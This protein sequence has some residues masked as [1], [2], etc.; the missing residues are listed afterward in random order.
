[1]AHRLFGLVLFL[2]S[3]FLQVQA[4]PVYAQAGLPGDVDANGELELA[5]A[6]L[7][8]RYI[9]GKIAD[10]PNAGMADVTQDGEVRVDDALAIAQR[11]S[12]QSRIVVIR[13]QYGTSA[14][15]FAGDVVRIE[16]F[17][18]FM[19]FNVTGGAARVVSASTGYDSGAMPLVFERDGRSLYCLWETGGLLPADDYSVYV[20]LTEVEA[21]GANSAYPLHLDAAAAAVPLTGVVSLSGRVFEIPQLEATVDAF[22]PSPGIPLVFRRVFPQDAYHSPY[23]G[24]LGR[25]WMHNFDVHLEEST[26]G[27]VAFLG[28]EGFNRFFTSNADGTYS[29]AP[30]DHALLARDPDGTFVLKEKDGFIYRFR[31]NLRLDFVEDTNGNRVTCSYDGAARLIEIAHSCGQSFSLEYNEYGRISRLTDHAGRQTTYQ[32]ELGGAHL[33][34]VTGPDGATTSYL[35]SLGKAAA[36]DHRLTQ[37]RRPDDTYVHITYDAGGRVASITGTWGASPNLFS[38]DADGTTHITDAVGAQATL[39]VNEL[40]QP[41]AVVEPD[42]G[43]TQMEYDSLAN[44]LQTTDPLGHVTQFGYDGFGNMTQVT[45]PLGHVARYTYEPQF[46][47]LSSVTDPLGDTTAMDY[48]SRGNLASVTYPDLTEDSYTYDAAGNMTV[49]ADP[50]GATTHY[51]YDSHCLM[52]SLEN[53]LGGV[54]GFTYDSAGALAGTLDANGHAI[55]LTRDGLGRLTRRTYPDAS[56]EDYQYDAG[57]KITSFTNRRGEQIGFEY[58]VAGRLEWKQYPSGKSLH[59]QYDPVGLLSSIEHVPTTGTPTL[60]SY[61]EYDSTGRVSL[62]RVPGSYS[63]QAYDVSYTYDA[64]GN[65]TSLTYPDGYVVRYEYDAADRLIRISDGTDSTIAAYEYDAAG[66]RTRRT[67]GNGTYTTY[68]YDSLNR[69]TRLV[70]RAPDG[71]VQSQFGYT[72]NAAGVRTSVTTLEGTHSYTYDQTYQLTAVQYPDGR[73]VQYAYDPVGSRTSVNDNGTVTDY[74]TNGLDQYTQAGEEALGY[75]ANGNVVS[76]ETST[77]LTIYGWDEDDRLVSVDR[78]GVRVEYRYDYRGRLVAKT[79]DGQETRHVWDELELIAEM[80]AAGEV[81]ARY[82]YGAALDE[83][84]LAA[85]GGTNYWCQQDGL[86]SVVGTT[87]DSGAVV[88]TASYDVYGSMRSGDLGPVPQRFAGMWWDG[89]AGLCHVRARW[90]DVGLGRFLTADPLRQVGTGTRYTYAGNDPINWVDPLG[91]IRLLPR[92][93]GQFFEGLVQ[94]TG[95]LASAAIGIF[96]AP[97]SA[98]TSFILSYTGAFTCGSGIMNMIN[99]YSTQNDSQ[100]ITGGLFGELALFSSAEWVHTAGKIT[101]YSISLRS[102]AARIMYR[103]G[104]ELLGTPELLSAVKDITTSARKL[105]SAFKKPGPPDSRSGWVYMRAARGWYFAGGACPTFVQPPDRHLMSAAGDA[106]PSAS[107]GDLTARITTPTDGCLLRSDIPIFGMA[108]GDD[109]QRYRVEY[110][111]GSNPAEWHLVSESDKPQETCPDFKDLSW[112]QGT[113]NITG[114][115]ATWNTGLK[116]WEHLPWHPAEDPTDLNGVY[117]IRLVVESKDGQTV[118]DRVTCEVGRAIAQCL[119]GIAVSPDRRVM[120]RFPEQALT[121][122]FR[123]YTILP[124]ESVGEVTPPAPAGCDLAGA[125]YRIR[126]PGDRFAKDVMLEFAASNTEMAGRDAGH[127]GIC[128]YDA[129]AGQWLWLDT[130]YAA[131]PGRFS[132]VLTELPMPK[133]IFALVFDPNSARRSHAPTLAAR[134]EPL[135]PAGPGVLVRDTFEEG[136]GGWKPRDRFVGA[137]IAR[138]NQVSPDSTYCLRVANESFGGNFSCTVLDQPF[139]VREYP[140]M[141]LDYRVPSWTKTDFYLLVGGRW[142]NLGF[143]DDPMDLRNADV[144]IAGLGRIPDVLADNRWHSASVNL[145]D[146]LRRKTRET[147]VDAIIMADWDAPAYMKLDF[148]RNVRGA[149]YYIDNFSLSAQATTIDSDVMVLDSFDGT[150][151]RNAFGGA[152]GTFSKPGTEL[153]RARIVAD[154]TNGRTGK[155]ANKALELTYDTSLPGTYCGY[156]TALMAADLESMGELSF[157]VQGGNSVPP[158]TIGLR[159]CKGSEARVVV[160]PY[161]APSGDDGWQMATIPLS[162]FQGLPDL[163]LLDSVFFTFENA[164]RSGKGTVFIDD[165][166]FGSQQSFRKVVDATAPGER[167]PLG[168][169]FRVVENGAAAVSAARHPDKRAGGTATDCY[170]ISYGG[171][172]GLDYGEQ[173]FSYGVWETDLLGFD[174]SS[175]KHLVLRVRGEKGGETPNVYLDDGTTRRCLRAGA[176][177]PALTSEWQEIRLPLS[178]FAKRSPFG[179]DLSHLV[180][181]QIVFEWVSMSGTMYV[182]EIRFE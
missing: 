151:G 127:I 90:Y 30:G 167:N 6:R 171:N 46:N 27:R 122:P 72:H 29:G 168:G 99:S 63:E 172:I 42:G 69:L 35:Y 103:A 118:E 104:Q 23:L 92:R 180:A 13:N 161:L 34:S 142:Y 1:M 174:A 15:T 111:E 65:R 120:M 125:V 113:L 80:N 143:T 37:I 139:D 124:L 2:S 170:R 71:A 148:G 74:A 109:F 47:N 156:W 19:P 100:L 86:G 131:D 66:R 119:P 26:E 114:N 5:D 117:T 51:A 134:S 87:N 108:A 36:S 181:L 165:L 157:R 152:S 18:R 20:D 121:A 173:G 24:P 38:Y 10:L 178:A 32:Y 22:A 8:V 49:H 145:Y 43:L 141:S 115:L 136:L 12:G 135:K 68:E 95:G 126:E 75:D 138:D 82:V 50:E 107:A 97:P 14:S 175:R 44:L 28:P 133:A 76:R 64:A 155:S 102:G 78:G 150:S 9:V 147:Q 21:T 55:S 160:A 94:F 98:G 132:T 105:W 17:E 73:N 61:Y 123:M 159:H 41:V 112:M 56:H 96:V 110:G 57:G 153:C 54:T 84:L 93:P 83:V 60:D 45:D 58:D 163:S 79:V 59:F 81:T 166:R 25:G 140:V 101:D 146:L 89:D 11:V 106:R 116:N 48:D 162:A 85:A 128:R 70:N 4:P 33:A 177:F 53:A 179:V 88:Q 154:E 16:V 137:S 39:R 77:D 149:T 158:L 7:L 144:N 130:V 91:M 31:T 52:T 169:E 40:G 3:L 67:L 182:S 176:D 129:A 164:L 62:A